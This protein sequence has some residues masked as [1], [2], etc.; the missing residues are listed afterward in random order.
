MIYYKSY[1]NSFN[2]P[3]VFMLT[4]TKLIIDDP[5]GW[6]P[7]PESLSFISDTVVAYKQAIKTT[8]NNADFI[9]Y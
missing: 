5:K 8:I 4:L 9:L 7:Y 6:S 2:D 3:P 1:F